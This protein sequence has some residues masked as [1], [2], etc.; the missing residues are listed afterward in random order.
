MD[1]MKRQKDMTQEHEPLCSEGVHSLCIQSL[2]DDYY[3]FC[4]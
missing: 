1:T 4:R 3:A 2:T